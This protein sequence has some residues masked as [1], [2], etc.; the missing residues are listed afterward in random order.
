MDLPHHGIAANSTRLGLGV[1]YVAADPS[2]TPFAAAKEGYITAVGAEN[3]I[4]DSLA[5]RHE[6]LYLS[7]T[8]QVLPMDFDT[9]S[10]VPRIDS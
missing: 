2:T 9:K 3:T 1:D 5:E 4:L 6:N 8:G 7:A 10:F